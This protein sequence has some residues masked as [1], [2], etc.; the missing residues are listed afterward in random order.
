MFIYKLR[1]LRNSFVHDNSIWSA[2]RAKR[3]SKIFTGNEDQN[4]NLVFDSI[5]IRVGERIKSFEAK[6]FKRIVD[7]AYEIVRDLEE[8]N[9]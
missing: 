9:G 8:E 4:F 3:L 1:E 7:T 2:K 6:Q 5:E